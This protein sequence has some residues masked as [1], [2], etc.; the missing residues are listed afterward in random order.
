MQTGAELFFRS[1]VEQAFEFFWSVEAEDF[2]AAGCW[3]QP[4]G[5]SGDDAGRFVGEWERQFVVWD[6]VGE[7]FGVFVR[8]RFDARERVAFFFGFDDASDFAVDVKNIVRLTRDERKLANSDSDASDNV[9]VGNVLDD[10]AALFEKPVDS[11]SG[12]GF[13]GGHYGCSMG[14]SVE[15]FAWTLSM[16]TK[17]NLF[18]FAGRRMFF[19]LLVRGD[20]MTV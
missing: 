20:T 11:L 5:E 7:P 15:K 14:Q 16:I 4:V 12:F 2:A 19:D 13:G 6:A 8:L 18:A 17:A 1:K 9:D 10:P 3:V